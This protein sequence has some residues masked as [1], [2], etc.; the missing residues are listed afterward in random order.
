[1]T[2]KINFLEICG[3]AL[4]LGAAQGFSIA[5]HWALIQLLSLAGICF[6]FLYSSS[7]ARSTFLGFLFGLGWFS[8]SVYWIYFSIHDYG[9]QP[10][11]VA[12]IAV[13]AFASLLAI[14][15]AAAGLLS[16]LGLRDRSR[17]NWVFFLLIAPA[18]WALTEWLRTWVL[19]GFPWAAG[20]YAHIEG[21]LSVFAPVIGATG[22]NYLAALTAGLICLFVLSMKRRDIW[23]ANLVAV[24][25]FAL[26]GS[27]FLL[28]EK[29]WSE[30][31]ETVNFRLIQGGIAQ[32]EKFSPM[33]TE[34]SF[35][36]YTEEMSAPGLKKDAVIVL[37]ETIFPIPFDK[38]P[39]KMLKELTK[40]TE[41]KGNPLILGA[42]IRSPEGGYANTAILIEKGSKFGF[43]F[44]KHLVPFGEYVPFGFRWFI[45]MLGI[46]MA[47]LKEGNVS[48]E[49][50]TVVDQ[51]SVVPTL[52]YEDLFSE[53]IRQWWSKGEAPG[54]L[55]N[56]SNLGWF[57]DSAALP[58]HLSISRMRAKEFARP[59]VRATNTGATAA[60]NEKGQIIARL[61]F[62]VPGKLDVAVTA[63]IGKPTPY[64]SLG[65]L[66]SVLVMLL[67]LAAGIG[68]TWCR[69]PK[70]SSQH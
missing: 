1:M 3:F 30:P 27:A 35:A 25:F 29:T 54:I 41:E 65:D 51:V 58:Q 16:G 6:L 10:A 13:V 4:V 24:A 47:N 7:V 36:R 70:A 68:L 50:F 39:T 55:I 67:S 48:Q 45:D 40:V 59:I 37:P 56:L 12:V 49:P 32:N 17:K 66:P 33:G 42:F 28:K 60:I 5:P 63:A 64:A 57:G 21:P 26:L 19:S 69:K 31:G 23:T 34:Q 2:R 53:T 44:K 22:I 52:C 20:A 14:F 61:P 11:W 46:P 18:A 9:Y 62:M 15:P 43:Y 38:L 8:S